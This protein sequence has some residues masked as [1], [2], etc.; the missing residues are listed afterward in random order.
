MGQ[1]CQRRGRASLSRSGA[2]HGTGA[3][4]LRVAT[5][6]ETV[7]RGARH[8]KK[9]RGVLCQKRGVK[10][11]F[12]RDH[13]PEFRV[14]AMCR[15]LEVGASGYYRWQGRQPSARDMENERR[16]EKIKAPHAESRSISGSPKIYRKL[17]R[18]GERVNHKRVARL[19][20]EPGLTARRVK[21]SKR[22]T[23]SRHSLP[24]ADNVLA[25]DFK[26]PRP[27]AVWV[28]DST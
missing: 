18:D 23:D 8:P 9:G 10:D 1:S 17:R 24:V 13:D 11:A 3:R 26:V 5:T 22:T 19:M 12:I 6:G 4:D 21:Q 15:V 27:D 7:G 28:S 2:T 25:R 20:K 16:V 14:A